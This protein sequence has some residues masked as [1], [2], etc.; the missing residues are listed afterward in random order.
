MTVTGTLA[1]PKQPAPWKL[2]HFQRAD[3]VDVPA[4]YR[5]CRHMKNGFQC[6]TVYFAGRSSQP[7]CYRHR[8]DAGDVVRQPA[9]SERVAEVVNAL[10]TATQESF[11]ERIDA[12][13]RQLRNAADHCV[14]RGLIRRVEAGIYASLEARNK[15]TA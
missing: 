13:P 5:R 2:E 9:I 14:K 11:L 4:G 7:H 3:V 6:K 1:I 8:Q 12:T 15:S 10:G